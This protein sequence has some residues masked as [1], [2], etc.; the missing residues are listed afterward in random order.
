M[1]FIEIFTDLNSRARVFAILLAAAL[2]FAGVAYTQSRTKNRE[3]KA[4]KRGKC[5][6]IVIVL[7]EFKRNRES[8]INYTHYSSGELMHRTEEYNGKLE[9]VIELSQRLDMLM[10]IYTPEVL[11]ENLRT[12]GSLVELALLGHIKAMN[13]IQ[14][15]DDFTQPDYDKDLKAAN[16]L[17][18]K[19]FG[20]I[21]RLKE[22]VI[23]KA[24]K[25]SG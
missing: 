18:L 20:D 9:T 23:L 12:A 4:H 14:Q 11:K 1:W 5:E 2:G 6:E 7:L 17:W 16:S 15:G 8:L 19:G 21:N 24:R 22:A 10:G 25:L 3:N 13:I